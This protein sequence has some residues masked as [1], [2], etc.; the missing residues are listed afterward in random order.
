M[1]NSSYSHHDTLKNGLSYS[2]FVWFEIMFPTGTDK[3][4]SGFYLQAGVGLLNYK[5][6]TI[7]SY[8]TGRGG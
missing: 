7:V 2:D 8:A 1:Y 4:F 5:S 6:W 3:W